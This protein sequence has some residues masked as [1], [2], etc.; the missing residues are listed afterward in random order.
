[1]GEYPKEGG[2]ATL[3]SRCTIIF[4]F[5]CLFSPV[6]S[7]SPFFLKSNKVHF[8]ATFEL[9]EMLLEDNPLKA[10]PKRNKRKSRGNSESDQ[11]FMEM[12]LKFHAYSTL[13]SMD[14]LEFSPLPACSLL[15]CF[16]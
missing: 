8:D 5:V 12:E 2:N 9:E 3:D 15:S 10:T 6:N 13:T 11:Q 16:V 14:H 4:F 1:M 7:N